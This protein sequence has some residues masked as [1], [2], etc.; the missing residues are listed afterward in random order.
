MTTTPEPNTPG[1]RDWDAEFAEI[2]GRLDGLVD[3]AAGRQT[4]RANRDTI[5]SEPWFPAA[6]EAEDREGDRPAP[7][8]VAGFREQWRAPDEF[9][10]SYPVGVTLHPADDTPPEDDFVPPAP[11]PLDSDDPSTAIMIGCLVAGPLWLLYLAVFD[12]D[13]SM[14]WWLLAALT[15]ATGFVLAVMRQPRRRDDEDDDGARV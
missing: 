7:S 13:T 2:T 3:D 1:E 5:P 14:L 15:L 8:S 12:R 11:Q 10:D 9:S 4:A 6:R